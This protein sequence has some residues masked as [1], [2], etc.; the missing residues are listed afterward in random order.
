MN[1]EQLDEF[2]SHVASGHL[3]VVLTRK[4]D[5]NEDDIAKLKKSKPKA[6]NLGELYA[7]KYR[8]KINLNE[9]N[10][11]GVQK[12]HQRVHLAF[13]GDLP[14]ECVKIEADKC[15]VLVEISLSEPLNPL[16][17]EAKPKPEELLGHR[18]KAAQKGG[19]LARL[20]E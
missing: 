11:P 6:L 17:E 18:E 16:V 7:A 19:L 2:E 9:L 8:G 4:P 15:Y 3:E 20:T 12:L 1:R 5:M 10:Q 14:A 13:A